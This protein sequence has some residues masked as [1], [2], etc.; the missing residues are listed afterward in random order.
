MSFDPSTFFEMEEQASAPDHS[1]WAE[2]YRPKAADDFIGNQSIKDGLRRWVGE[3]EIP[4]LLLY[5]SPGT[6]KTSLGKLITTLIPCDSLMINASDENGVDDIRN[7]VQDF[8]IT[9]GIHSLKI[10]FLDEADRMTPDAQGILRNLMEAYSQSTRF[11]LTCNYKDKIT[12]AIWSRCQTFEIKPPSKSEAAKHLAKI[13]SKEQI[14]YKPE[15]VAF[16]VNS[17]FPDLRK[18][19][20]YAQQ[21]SVGGE[22]KIVKANAADQDYKTKLVELLKL[23]QTKAGIFGDIRQLVADASFSNYDE[24]YRYLFDHINEY[25]SPDKAPIVI[26]H[27][28]EAIYQSALV[29]EREITFVAAMHKLITALNGK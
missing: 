22:I 18:I 5:G 14:T 4:H 28:A 10:M 11:I 15:D 6:G 16:I 13:L 25:A 7:K 3:K 9:M 26:L 8:C 23:S 19:I 1:I 24:V 17:Y 27:L 12:P 2:R 21:S 29:F 20:N